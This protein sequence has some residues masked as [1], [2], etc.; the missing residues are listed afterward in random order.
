MYLYDLRR[1][2]NQAWAV[3]AFQSLTADIQNA[4]GASDQ[5]QSALALACTFGAVEDVEEMLL[6]WEELNPGQG[7]QSL[8]PQLDLAALHGHGEVVDILLRR[9]I[10]MDAQTGQSIPVF[11]AFIDAWDWSINDDINNRGTPLQIAAW[12]GHMELAQWMIDHGADPNHYQRNFQWTT[13][14]TACQ[15]SLAMVKLL[16][17]NGASIHDSGAMHAA[18]RRGRIDVLAFLLYLGADIDEVPTSAWILHSEPQISTP[19]HAAVK[20]NQ[21]S[22]VSFLLARGADIS[23]ENSEGK[24]ILEV[25]RDSPYREL[26]ELIQ[27]RRQN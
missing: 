1:L 19:L 10:T 12:R 17:K 6:S 9:G 7:F 5:V 15:S 20:E 16:L 8:K 14:A 27:W 11:Q 24:T 18:A 22:A 2:L 26:A 4:M 21:R 13:L 3:V 23:V 25:A